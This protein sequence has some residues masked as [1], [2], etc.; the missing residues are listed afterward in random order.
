[1]KNLVV[2]ALGVMLL[3]SCSKEK[4]SETVAENPAYGQG[5]VRPDLAD[6]PYVNPETAPV[7][8][9]AQYEH[10]FGPLTYAKGGKV[11]H[12]FTFTNT[13][14]SA[15]IIESV[16]ASCGCTVPSPPKEPFA[17]GES[18]EIFVEYTPKSHNGTQGSSVTVKS[19]TVKGTDILR[20]TANVSGAPGQQ[21]NAAPAGLQAAPTAPNS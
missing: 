9:F 13:G 5:P 14:K 18:G 8:A 21:K 7:L 11:S 3:M 4:P 17:P 12:N 10:D 20:I 19:N 15:L 1:M 2:T 6:K 16:K